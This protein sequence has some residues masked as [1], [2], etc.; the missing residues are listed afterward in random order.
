MFDC[1][2]EIA[3][4]KVAVGKEHDCLRDSFA[5]KS[6][7]PVAIRFHMLTKHIARYQPTSRLVGFA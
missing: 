1:V 7:Q 3:G 2:A 5:A 6:D 4:L